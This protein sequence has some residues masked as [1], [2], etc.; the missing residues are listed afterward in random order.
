MVLSSFTFAFSA[1]KKIK[2]VNVRVTT[3]PVGQGDSTMIECA[4]NNGNFGPEAGG[5]ITFI[6]MGSTKSDTIQK[7]DFLKEVWDYTNA[8]KRIKRIF[9]THPD[10]DHV[11]WAF[12][13]ELKIPNSMLTM[14][15][16]SKQN[17]EIHVGYRDMWTKVPASASAQLVDYID[18]T[19]NNLKLIDQS[20]RG[21]GKRIH[22]CGDKTQ[23]VDLIVIDSGFRKPL[24]NPTNNKNSNSMVMKLVVGTGINVVRMLFVGDL[25]NDE[26]AGATE[27]INNIINNPSIEAEVVMIPHHGS[28]SH[29][30][31]ENG[32][33]FFEAVGAKYGI[34]SSNIEHTHH[35][36]KL[37]TVRA[38]C[39][40]DPKT[41]E[42][43]DM[44][45][46]TT[47]N[48]DN[49]NL[50]KRP[51]VCPTGTNWI[52]AWK[53]NGNKWEAHVTNGCKS[54]KKF[55]YQTTY[56][57][58]TDRA[59]KGTAKSNIIFTELQQNGNI[60]INKKP[61]TSNSQF[62]NPIKKIKKN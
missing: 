56:F 62:I 53:W 1:V 44:K 48:G 58:P 14:L 42:S 17:V 61:V 52:T 20:S 36:P 39:Q 18:K 23:D 5:N 30:W 57:D 37:Q 16:N 27:V 26:K 59:S 32:P 46:R 25:E 13:K 33:A 34:I 31:E 15:G 51:A 12:T 28:S 29:G 2:P 4:D 41:S 40:E 47:Y 60:I 54:K 49:P 21:I 11:N 9:L 6:D 43:C 10:A 8:G 7:N 3:L 24:K 50:K 35:H 22:L 45:T 55:I 19:D 38:F